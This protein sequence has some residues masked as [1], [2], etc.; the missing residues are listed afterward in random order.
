MENKPGKK[1]NFHYSDQDIATH[2]M[3]RPVEVFLPIGKEYIGIYIAMYYKEYDEEK[4]GKR[5][6]YLFTDRRGE[7]LFPLHN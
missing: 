4:A 1:P 3:S 6:G 5:H 7:Y 2:E